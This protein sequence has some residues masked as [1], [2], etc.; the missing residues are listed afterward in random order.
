MKQALRTLGLFI[1]VFTASTVVYLAFYAEDKVQQDIMGHSLSLLGDKLFA[2]VEDGAGKDRLVSIYNEFKER[3][4]NHDLPR[5]RVA[6]VAA[7]ILNASSKEKELTP[8]QAEGVLRAGMIAAVHPVPEVPPLDSAEAVR[9]VKPPD[10]DLPLESEKAKWATLAQDLKI[11]CDFDDSLRL[12]VRPGIDEPAAAARFYYQSRNGLRL[13]VDPALSGELEQ[14]EL[15]LRFEIQTRQLEKR[16]LITWQH[17]V[18]AEL[19]REHAAAEK[20][21]HFIKMTL[22]SLGR[23]HVVEAARNL[24][25]LASLEQLEH[26]PIMNRDSLR[27]LVER[28]LRTLREKR[29]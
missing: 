15:R 29:N 24:E 10:V 23:A 1:A 2:M 20:E 27:D 28:E 17:Q 19:E 8:E 25:S 21:L 9:T 22:D 4:L 13:V 5:A 26:I 7:N 16:K 6:S 12:T 11:M 14:P 18:A 3:A